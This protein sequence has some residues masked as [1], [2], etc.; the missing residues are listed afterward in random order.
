MTDNDE[1]DAQW[2]PLRGLRVLDFSGLLP[3]PFATLALADLGADVIKVEPPG[4]DPAR[5]ILKTM[6]R[7]AN[8]NKRSMVVDLKHAQA[9]TVVERLARG[10]D[11]AIEAFRPGVA[12]RLGI[13]Y[14]S[15]VP[16]NPALVYCSISGYGQTG[17]DRLRPGHDVNY[18][19]RSGALA[20]AGH[21][22]EPPRRSGLPIADVTGGSF[23]AIAI[24]AALQERQATGRGAYLDLSLAEAAM[25]LAALRHGL[26]FD[27]RA[28]THVRPTND[29][30]QTADGQWIALGVV[31][32]HFWEGFV[33]A[34]AEFAPDLRD[35]RFGSIDSRLQ[36]GNAVSSRLHEVIRMRDA[37][38]WLP[39]FKQHD[40]PAELVLAPVAAS[41]TPQIASRDT[42][43]E[44]D[45]ERHI[46]FPVHANGRRGAAL[47]STAPALGAHTH[48][49]LA[50]FGFD[51]AEIAQLKH[52]SAVG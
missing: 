36:N 43:R 33:D 4:G 51:L 18:L 49:I 2:L 40:V 9:R 35:K 23:A 10:T 37:A 39:L 52:T 32:Q 12:K 6:Y 24:L 46:P 5:Q 50:E 48:A 7:M 42:V 13:D 16:F 41:R 17:P 27:G 38:F 26:D 28:Q 11:V 29:L 8:R 30:F 22:N 34:V 14:A 21:W 25:S 19:A 15:L 47:R 44:A 20:L 45:G 1:A 31:E 3:G